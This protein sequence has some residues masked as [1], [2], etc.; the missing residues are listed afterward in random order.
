MIFYCLITKYI[1]V[2]VLLYEIHDNPF[3]VFTCYTLIQRER[4]K[5]QLFFT[6]RGGG[7]GPVLARRGDRR[8]ARFS[9]EQTIFLPRWLC[10]GVDHTN[11]L[12]ALPVPATEELW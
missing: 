10:S 4:E 12:R 6:F 3:T 8:N 9:S 11:V 2:G 5:N 1:T 7:D